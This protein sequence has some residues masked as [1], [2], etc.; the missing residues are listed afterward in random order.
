MPWT[1][2]PRSPATESSHAGLVNDRCSGSDVYQYRAP[3]NR[4]VRASKFPVLMMTSP[5]G[6][7]KLVMRPRKSPGEDTCSITSKATAASN[8]RSGSTVARV[9]PTILTP[10]IGGPLSGW[11]TDFDAEFLYLRRQGPEERSVETAYVQNTLCTRSGE[12][13]RSKLPIRS[14][15]RHVGPLIGLRLLVEQR[16]LFF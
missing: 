14:F 16:E 4:R 1:R 9:S 13:S 7:T 10:P 11:P 3:M 2:R 5:P 12:L 6:R 8:C 15:P